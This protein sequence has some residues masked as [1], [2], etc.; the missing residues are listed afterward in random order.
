[1]SSEDKDSQEVLAKT[2]TSM[3]EKARL[4]EKA[5]VSKHTGRVV[6]IEKN[7]SICMIDKKKER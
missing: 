5:E 3:R 1:M 2:T 6:V 7:P 4:S